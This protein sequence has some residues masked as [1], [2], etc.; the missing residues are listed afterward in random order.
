MDSI[1]FDY[2][3]SSLRILNNGHTIQANYDEGSKISL[4]DKVYH[5][6]QFHFHRP[7]EHTLKGKQF[8]MEAH[9]VHAAE[10]GNLAVV[11]V[12]LKTGKENSFVQRLW[13]NLPSHVGQEKTVEGQIQVTDLL[14]EDRSFFHYSGS[15]TT[16]P[17][18]EGVSWY[19]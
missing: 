13:D 5:L 9:L 1:G 10:D 2:R 12:F 19:V 17:C 6:L 4:G 18:T 7:S 15:L 14:P 11:G 3:S 16:P 8:I